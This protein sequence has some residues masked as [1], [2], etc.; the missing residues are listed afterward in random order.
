MARSSTD[1]RQIESSAQNAV[2]PFERTGESPYDV[3]HHL[4]KM[5]QDLVGIVRREPEMQ[6][7]LDELSQLEQRA[8][9]VAVMG[10]R[11]YNGGWHT[12]LDLPNLLTVSKMITRAAMERK[13]SR[14]AH[15]REDYPSKN[16]EEGR[17]NIVIRQSG[18][19]EM[20]VTREPLKPLPDGAKAGD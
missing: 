12:A 16:D 1:P 3:Q 4:Q 9:Q 6:Q 10:N 14:G 20:Q 19:G 7:A 8:N 13:E 5:M 17:S 2:E 18:S 11:E 15:F